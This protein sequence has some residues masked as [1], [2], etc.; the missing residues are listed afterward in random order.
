MT[1]GNLRLAHAAIQVAKGNITPEQMAAYDASLK[2]HEDKHE[3]SGDTELSSIGKAEA[4]SLANFWGPMLQPV[5]KDKKLHVYVSPMQRCL[6]TADPLMTDLNHV[7]KVYPKIFE[8]PGLCEKSDRDF[9]TNTLEP[10]I[11]K[12]NMSEAIKLYNSHTFHDA[13]LSE[14]AI[15]F[16]FP[17]INE[18]MMFPKN[19]N[20][21]WYNESDGYRGWETPEATLQRAKDAVNFLKQQAQILP[22]DHTILFVSHGDYLG[23]LINVLLGL[24]KLSHSLNNTSVSSF[25]IRK[26][27]EVVMEFYNRIPHIKLERQLVLYES[28]GFKEKRSKNGKKHIDIGEM[29]RV[30]RGTSRFPIYGKLLAA[31]GSP[32][33]KL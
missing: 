5:A 18:V 12:K 21:P 23:E 14:N 22:E 8:S 15:K 1:K 19:K 33:S 31:L 29:M 17:W 20:R 11:L 9:I 6:Q 24:H 7:G 25:K 32:V 10:L 28:M 26:D 13:G 4:E 2:E 16:R 3:W 27:G 30:K